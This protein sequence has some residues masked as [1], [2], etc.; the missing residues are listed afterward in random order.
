M[1]SEDSVAFRIYYQDAVSPPPAGFA[2]DEVIR[3]RSVDVAILVPTT[4]DQVD[5]HPEALVENLQPRFVLLGHWEDFFVPIDEPTKSILLTDVRYFERRL[6]SVHD[7]E[8]WRPEKGTEFLF[9]TGR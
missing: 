1:A 2:P 5:W 9:P 4:F 6:E 3:G 7:G 8:W